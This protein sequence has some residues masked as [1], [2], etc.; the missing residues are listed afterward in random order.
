MKRMLI[1]ATQPEE[2]RVALVDGQKLYDLDIEHTNR[3]QEKANIYKGKITRVEPSLEAAFVDYGAERHGFLSLKEI[4]REYFTKQPNEIEGRINIRDVIREGQEVIVQ[5]DKEER[6]NKGAALTTFISLAGRYLVLMPNNPRAGG[7]SRRI[8]GDDRDELKDALAGLDLP[9]GMGTIVRT[10][11]IGR[12]AEELQWDLDYLLQ[13]WTSIKKEADNSKAPHFLFQ[14]SNVVIRA[15][16]D[17][18][19]QDISEVII[20]TRNAYELASA[21]IQQVMPNYQ[22]KVKF[23]QDAIPLFNRYQIEGQIESAFEREVKLPSGGAIVIDVTEALVSIDI[24]SSR[25][26]KGGDIE[27]TATNTNLEAADEIAR[28]LRLRDIGGLV[29]IDF[30][31]MNS[32]K[33]QRAVEERVRDALQMDRA[34]VQVGRISRFGLLEMSRQ[35]LRPSLGETSGH[36]CPRCSGQGTIR[37]TKSIALALLRM[38]EEEAQKE[39]S[40][41]VRAI[42]PVPVASFL[43]NE[44]RKQI[45]EIEKRHQCR[46]VIV[47]SPDLVTPHYHIQRLRDDDAQLAQTSF[48]IGLSDINNGEEEHLEQN[49][50]PIK[51]AAVQILVPNTPAPIPTATVEAPAAAPAAAAAPEKKEPG[52]L[53]RIIGKLFGDE[54]KPEEKVPAQEP[55]QEKQRERSNGNNPQDARR[56]GNRGGRGRGGR[57]RNDRGGERGE[58]PRNNHPQRERTPQGE[59]SN[60]TNNRPPR[61]PQP[62]DQQ[63]P[64]ETGPREQ[65][66]AR[67]QQAR[68]PQQER[69]PQERPAH[70]GQAVSDSADAPARR[71]NNK[72]PRNDRQR[73]RPRPEGDLSAPT[74]QV[75]TNDQQIDAPQFGRPAQPADRPAQDQRP[76]RPRP[77][78]SE[79]TAAT[80]TPPVPAA[81]QPAVSRADAPQE[82][83]R[84]A[85]TRPPAVAPQEQ[86][87]AVPPAVAAPTTTP[88]VNRPVSPQTSLPGIEPTPATAKPAEPHTPRPRTRPSNDPRAQGRKEPREFVILTEEAKIPE[89]R[90]PTEMVQPDPQRQRR[91]PPNDPRAKRA[92]ESSETS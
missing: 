62:R 1:N 22:S 26:T 86:A 4:S 19:R 52:F 50:A 33:N 7:I 25:S 18:L 11:G 57:D 12:S 54:Q 36:I 61:S 29:V 88:T 89:P 68:P 42:T 43:L 46:V 27:E 58:Q 59:N 56:R 41:E 35:R 80:S 92:A 85:A 40:S 55:V 30:I 74:D 6:G 90:I 60:P 78:I 53:S 3:R 23:Y 32:P 38:L 13:L 71:P 51:T 73:Q 24:N 16:R 14:E 10:A 44:K 39:R 72:R 82:Q 5:I 69:A 79:E 83:Q 9:P 28:Q 37:G 20:D 87:T 49:Q 91:R 47:P 34:R 65:P 63:A 45:S 2:L 64:R 15:I 48:E 17:Y 84:P 8:E 67:E 76:P 66:V 81:P 77:E 70:G 31:D 75:T 21:F